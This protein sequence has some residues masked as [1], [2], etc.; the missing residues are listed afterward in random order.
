MLDNELQR[1]GSQLST[2]P[3][4]LDLGC[5]NGR[6]SLYL[7]KKYKSSDV[8]L[9]D[10]DLGMLKWAEEL[11]SLQGGSA[12]SICT[13]V[14]ELASKPCRLNEKTGISKFDIVIFSYVIQH[15]D[16]VYYPIVF[17]FCKKICSGYMAIGVFWNPSRLNVGD[18]TRIGTVS[19]YGLSYEELVI[20]L[21]PRFRVINDRVLRTSISVMINMVLTEGQTPLAFVLKRNY[22]YYS[23]RIKHRRSTGTDSLTRHI[24]R[25]IN[26]D[27]LQC[28]KVLSSLYPSEFDLV[29]TEMVQWIQN[30]NMLTPS[31]MAAKFLWYCRINKIPTMFSE[32]SKNFGVLPKKVMQVMSGTEQYIPA[33][34]TKEYVERISK[35]L[36]L[37]DRITET[38]IDLVN[39]YEEGSP[40]IRACCAVIKAADKCGLKIR[41][42]ILHQHWMLLQQVYASH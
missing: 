14:E 23:G 8:V 37:T 1:Q 3:T 39:Q 24:K 27:D 10:C 7:A 5:G 6:N 16:P 29:R 21:A 20:L 41:L 28:T 15:I 22:E 11:F 25:I 19:W 2:P 12:K 40:T 33:L 32:V 34:G 4:I 30:S 18:F 42:V 26:I 35:H 13:T 36:K 38:A 31:L 17:D 9:I